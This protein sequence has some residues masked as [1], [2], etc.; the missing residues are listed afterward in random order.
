MSFSQCLQ[1][2]TESIQAS[3]TCSMVK[4]LLTLSL[5]PSQLQNSY[6]T[7]SCPSYTDAVPDEFREANVTDFNWKCFVSGVNQ[8][9][10]PEKKVMF[11]CQ[12]IAGLLAAWCLLFPLMVS[13]PGLGLLFA[14]ILVIVQLGALYILSPENRCYEK[15]C[16]APSLQ[17]LCEKMQ[18]E[19]DRSGHDVKITCV[20]SGQL[21][22]RC[23]N[24]ATAETRRKGLGE[25]AKLDFTIEA[26]AEVFSS[27]AEATTTSVAT[28]PPAAAPAA[29]QPAGQALR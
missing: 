4:K 29:R 21:E 17:A 25:A 2:P 19:V 10:T 22:P 8:E 15:M 18:N 14:C 9:L 3:G 27:R 13:V 1:H 26:A 20:L 5:Q 6:G 16:A 28:D 23:V 11:L 24:D 12:I 7:E